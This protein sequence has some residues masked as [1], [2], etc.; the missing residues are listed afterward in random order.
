MSDTSPLPFSLLPNVLHASPEFASTIV[1]A[2]ADA[3]VVYDAAGRIM[4]GNTA[5]A[6]LLGLTLSGRGA[7]LAVPIGERASEADLRTLEGRP[8]PNEERPAVR[9]LRGETLSGTETVDVIARTADGQ[10]RILNVSGV[11]LV[12]A[13]GHVMGAVCVCRDITDRHHL[14]RELAERAAELESTFATQVEAVV[15]AD[16][17]G[18]IIRMN[19]A[20]RQLLIER[21]IN[22]KA[23]YIQ[24]WAQES[25]PYDALGQRVPRENLPF[26]QALGGER[27]TSEQAIELYHHAP[28]GR[29]LVLRVSGA[30]VRD[31]RGQILGAVLTTHDVTQQRHLEQ[32]LFEHAAQIE[33]IFEAMVDGVVLVDATAHI[34]RMNEAYRQL[35]GYDATREAVGSQFT[36]Y[37]ARRLP[38]DLENRLLPKDQWPTMRVLRGET[39]TGAHAVETRVRALDGR[40]LIVQISGAPVRDAAGHIIGGVTALRDITERHQLEQQRNDILRVVAHDLLSPITGVRL[41]LQT[42]QRRLRKGQPAFVP[43]DR[44]LDALDTNL[45]R[46]ERLVNDLREIAR[47]ESG[48]LTLERHPCDLVALCRQEVKVQH[49]LAPGRKIQLALPKEPILSEVDEQRT[50]QVLAN[51]LSNALKYSP[52]DQP[53]TLTLRVD[54]GVVQIAVHDKGPGIP[55]VELDHIWERF[56]RVEGITAQ[57]G[58]NSLGLG[59][60]ICRAIIERHGGQVGVESTVGVGST[61]W[62]TLLLSSTSVDGEQTR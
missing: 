8:L 57:D 11:P 41:Y 17:T 45:L 19:E 16:T 59:L 5:A 60:Y 25:E 54:D 43:G 46:M 50:G 10:Q 62:F 15:L 26:Y 58:S 49:L 1:D 61:F 24:T 14:E 23:E 22:P 18:R 35:L 40:E 32:E 34:V 29:D 37:A 38:R 48:A 12:D 6:T 52:A 20:Q 39:L 51:L 28:D 53:V 42:Q 30:P 13:D 21:G 55:A 27:I 9:V 44:G 47:I 2:L 7:A 31:A 36:D 56:Y 33:S 4:A 3:L